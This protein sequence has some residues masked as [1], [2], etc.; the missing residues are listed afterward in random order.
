M[1]KNEYIELLE[2]LIY[3][4]CHSLPLDEDHQD[5]LEKLL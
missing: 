1:N 4:L 2:D 3:R 5:V